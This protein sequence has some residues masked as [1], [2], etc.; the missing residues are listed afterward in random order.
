[1]MWTVIY[2]WQSDYA[3][4]RILCFRLPFTPGWKTIKH[5]TGALSDV[6]VFHPLIWWYLYRAFANCKLKE[7]KMRWRFLEK[8]PL[9]QVHFRETAWRKEIVFIQFGRISQQSKNI[10]IIFSYK[11]FSRTNGFLHHHWFA[12]VLGREP[13]WSWWSHYWC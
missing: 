10:I 7:W 13:Q 11:P 4:N 3:L 9:W 8:E 5:L 2:V 6:A 1:M 12:H